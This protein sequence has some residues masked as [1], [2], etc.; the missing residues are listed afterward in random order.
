VSSVILADAWPSIAWT[1]FTFA[2]LRSPA[3][4]FAGFDVA[5]VIEDEDL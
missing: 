4:R 3:M 1:L 5:E 2:R